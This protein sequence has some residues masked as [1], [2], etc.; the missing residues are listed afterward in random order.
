MTVREHVDRT[1]AGPTCRASHTGRAIAHGNVSAR[2][3]L[4]VPPPLPRVPSSPQLTRV[5]RQRIAWLGATPESWSTGNKS[6]PNADNRLCALD[7]FACG[8]RSAVVTGNTFV[9]KVTSPV[10]RSAD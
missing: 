6:A 10:R 9:R 3:S 7:F 5:G 1:I 8:F 2:K 4:R